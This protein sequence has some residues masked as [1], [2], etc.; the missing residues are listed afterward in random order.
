[1]LD[2]LSD[3]LLRY[4]QIVIEIQAH[5]ESFGDQSRANEIAKL[6]T[7]AVARYLVNRGV[8]VNRL[9]ARAF[10]HSQPVAPDDTDANRAQNN[11]IE[12]LV[13]P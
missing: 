12:L 8:P 2:Q 13:M 7:I 5:T 3:N 11:R 10:G 6:R 1:V 9:K 4:Q